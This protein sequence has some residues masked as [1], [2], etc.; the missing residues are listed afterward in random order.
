ME[1]S[2]SNGISTLTEESK[3]DVFKTRI[4]ESDVQT[5]SRGTWSNACEVKPWGYKRLGR[6]LSIQ[7]SLRR[8]WRRRKFHKIR[9]WPEFGNEEKH[10]GRK[11]ELY[12]HVQRCC[13]KWEREVEI[14]F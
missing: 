6:L 8:Q 7:G 12:D 5:R 9:P 11:C 3:C 14:S 10:E 1:L 4:T 2:T 13:E